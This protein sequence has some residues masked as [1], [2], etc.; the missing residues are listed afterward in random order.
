MVPY[1][2]MQLLVILTDSFFCR[3]SVQLNQCGFHGVNNRPYR[4]LGQVELND[5]QLILDGLGQSSP[6]PPSQ[7]QVLSLHVFEVI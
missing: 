7:E 3:R 4:D 1:F 6:N 2:I 5:G